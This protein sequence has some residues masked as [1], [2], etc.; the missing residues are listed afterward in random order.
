[1]GPGGFVG[2]TMGW[3]RRRGHRGGGLAACPNRG[4]G[5]GGA[6]HALTPREAAGTAQP[7]CDQL[8]KMLRDRA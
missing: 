8:I 4:A 1:M 3:R 2:L 5:A 7:H 6:Q